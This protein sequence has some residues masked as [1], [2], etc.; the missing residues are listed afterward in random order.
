MKLQYFPIIN[1]VVFLVCLK[2]VNKKNLETIQNV[3]EIFKNLMFNKVNL[4]KFLFAC[5]VKNKGLFWE[6]TNH[7]TR[8]P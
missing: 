4:A 8:N 2:H 6:L 5:L 7:E 3:V 1:V